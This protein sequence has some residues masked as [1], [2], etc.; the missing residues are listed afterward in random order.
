MGGFQFGYLL[1]RIIF[2]AVI[3]LVVVAIVRMAGRKR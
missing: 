3:V 2:L 1:G